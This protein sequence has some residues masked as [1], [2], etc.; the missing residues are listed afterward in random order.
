MQSLNDKQY[1]FL[2]VIVSLPFGHLLLSDFRELK[3]IL[4]EKKYC[5]RKK[6]K[7]KLLTL[8]EAVAK[9]EG[10]RILWSIY[11][12]PTTYYKLNGNT[13]VNQKGSFD[14]TTIHHYI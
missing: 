7:D 5:Y 9:N 12:Q 10:L 8:N 1:Y 3:K 14:F 6:E 2:D 11:S 4:F 13:K